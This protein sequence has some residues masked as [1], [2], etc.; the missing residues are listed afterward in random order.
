MVYSVEIWK[1]T[2]KQR[3]SMEVFQIVWSSHGWFMN[4][5]IVISFIILILSYLTMFIVCSVLVRLDTGG[6]KTKAVEKVDTSSVEKKEKS[7]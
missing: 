7:I 2:V 5:L 1:E 4:T 6:A 3:G